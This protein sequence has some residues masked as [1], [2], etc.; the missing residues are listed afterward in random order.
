MT[1]QVEICNLALKKFSQETILSIDEDE[2]SAILLKQLWEP[3]RDRCLRMHT[4]NFATKRQTLARLSDTPD[5]EFDFYYQLPADFLRE[6]R[7]YDNYHTYKIEGDRLLSNSESI[8]M[9][10]IAK[11][12]D[13]AKYDPLFVDYFATELAADVA[14][15]LS[16]SEDTTQRLKQEARDK[17]KTARRIDGQHGTP[18]PIITQ[19]NVVDSFYTLSNQY[20]INDSEVE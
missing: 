19:S 6:D 15:A 8:K 16:G 14:R 20:V 5:F 9:V 4:W 11:I 13:T 12:T 2:G 17:L 3:V 10:Y 7:L 18:E 1:S